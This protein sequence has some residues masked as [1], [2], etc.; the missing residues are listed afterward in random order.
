M[1]YWSG[2]LTV[3]GLTY[4]NYAKS[5]LLTPDNLSPTLHLS[6]DGIPIP[7]ADRDASGKLLIPDNAVIRGVEPDWRAQSVDQKTLNVEREIRP[8][9]I[10]DIGYLGVRGRHN[11]HSQNINQA[12]PSTN[13]NNNYQLTRPLSTLYP[14]LGDVPISVSRA[15]SYYNALTIRF[16]ANVGHDLYVNASYAHGRSFADG[17]NIDQNNIHQYYGPTQEDIAHIFNSEARYSLPVGR[18]KTFLGHSDR[19]L[20][21]LVGGWEFSSL[22]HMRSGARFDVTS[23]VSHLNNG[24]SNRPDRIGSGKLSHPT[25]ADWFDTS[26][27]IDHAGQGT[28]GDAGINPLYGD[29][30][31]Q[32]D[33]SLEKKFSL[34]ESAELQFRVDAFNT[35]NHPDFALPDST[36]GDGGEGQITSTSVDN[37]RLQ[38]SLRL[39]F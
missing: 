9:M 16:A 26:A 37:R 32:L 15:D 28:Y 18:G 4:P 20:D 25:I 10:V 30:Q 31:V 24:Q 39:S 34:F 2:P 35:F 1:A 22:L 12:P 8:G 29:D 33:S 38:L 7:T 21:T 19:L 14:T 23:G 11:L 13:P 3:L 5:A 36:V 6:K 27:F 17:N